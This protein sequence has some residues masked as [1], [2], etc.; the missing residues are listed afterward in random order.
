MR[1]VTPPPSVRESAL[2]R[3]VLLDGLLA[4]LAEF[5]ALEVDLMI[6]AKGHQSHRRFE[7][8]ELYRIVQE[9]LSMIRASLP[10]TVEIRQTIAPH[11]G[12]VLADVTCVRGVA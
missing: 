6:G 3:V 1:G 9:A 5:G 2:D 11:A 10:A 7:A 4:H 12:S 8:V